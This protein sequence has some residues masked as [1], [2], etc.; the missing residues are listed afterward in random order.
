[1]C[2]LLGQKPLSLKEDT[3]DVATKSFTVFLFQMST[4]ECSHDTYS[5]NRSRYS[6]NWDK[7]I[8]AGGRFRFGLDI[9][10]TSVQLLYEHH[11]SCGLRA[12]Y[13]IFTHIFTHIFIEP[14]GLKYMFN[15]LSH[16]SL[17][18]S[19]LTAGGYTRQPGKGDTR[20]ELRW[21]QCARRSVHPNQKPT[22]R[23]RWICI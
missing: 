1:M 5:L 17:C 15:P 2:A 9:G 14:G 20:K 10:E 6:F 13:S 22:K 7:Y 8:Q 11:A 16:G 4:M 12:L 19:R 3:K 18:V 23:I 21:F